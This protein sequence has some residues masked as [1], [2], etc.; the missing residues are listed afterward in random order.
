METVLFNRSY[1]YISKVAGRTGDS[2]P[3]LFSYP[4]PHSISTFWQI[5]SIG[6]E[7][8]TSLISKK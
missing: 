1:E 3:V 7:T 6:Q 4:L 8:K 2:D 5:R